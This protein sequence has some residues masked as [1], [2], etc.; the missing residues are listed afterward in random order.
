MRYLRYIS[1]NLKTFMKIAWLSMLRNYWTK[2]GW[3]PDSCNPG[4][5]TAEQIFPVQKIW[6]IQEHAKDLYTC[7]VDL[8]KA[9]DRVP[10]EK[11][12]R[13]LPEYSVAWY[14]LSGH[15][16]PN[17]NFV[18]VSAEFNHI[19]S[20]WVMQNP[21]RTA[22]SFPYSAW[23]ALKVTAESIWVYLLEAAWSTFSVLRTIKCWCL[24]LNK[25]SN[26]YLIDD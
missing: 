14:W 2:V 26:M 18:S 13:M 9:Y 8:E 4:I 24:I 19:R 1:P 15:C 22:K 6:E 20:Y 11:I 17:Q 7:F 5:R 16:I 25:A 23:I 12:W 3:C 21:L 10:R